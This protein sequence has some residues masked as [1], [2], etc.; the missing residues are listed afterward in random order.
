MTGPLSPRAEALARR[1]RESLVV[2]DGSTG[3]VLESLSGLHG[4]ALALLPLSR[5]E[6]VEALHGA[7]FAAGSDL[8]ETATFQANA[9]GLEGA[10]RRGVELDGAACHDAS[11]IAYRVNLEAARAAR[12]A[13]G[14]SPSRWVAG[15][16]GPGDRPPSLGASTWAGLKASYLPQAR[17][18]ADG[19]CDLALIETCQDPLQAKAAVA[20]LADPHGGRGLPFI[21]SATVDASGRLLAGTSI[22]AFVAIMAP[23]RPLAIGLNCSGGPAEL[24]P[25]LAE[26]A[27]LSPCPL[28]FMPNAG[29]PREEGGT[30]LWPLGPAEFAALVA[31]LA[32]RHGVSV[33]GGCCGTG[34][35]HLAR[36]SALL[37]DRPHPAPRP[38]PRPGLASLY[39][40]WPFFAPP[41]V[42]AG[43]AGSAR[44]FFRIGER[45]NSAGS[46]AFGSLIASGDFDG[47][48]AKAV[49]QEATGAQ[50]LDLHVSRPG[51]DEAIDLAGLAARLSG[52]ARA[53]ICLD[54]SEPAALEAALPAV[55]GRPL[56]NSAS[57]EDEA[58]ARRVFA[59]ARDFGAAVVCLAMDSHGPARTA[60][61]KARTCRALYDLAV[62]DFDLDPA[63]LLF[64][65]LTFTV[66]AGPPGSAAETLRAIP[67]IKAAC[68]GSLVVLGVGNISFGLPRAA[69]PSVTAVFL[70]LALEAGLDAAILDT[71]GVPEP[72]AVDPAI[73][74]AALALIHG[75]PEEGYDPLEV[76]GGAG[77]AS[78]QAADASAR[79]AAGAA[80]A[81][82]PEARLEAALLRGDRKVA[83]TEAKAILAAGGPTALAGAV[84]AAMAESGRLWLAG[85][86]P[87]PLV[88]RA[89]EAAK[90]VLALG[91]GMAGAPS[92]GC[93][94]L[95]TVKGDLHDIGKNIAGAI[96]AC[97]G[98]RVVDLGTDVDAPAIVAAAARESAFAVGLSGLLTRSLAE[99]RRTCEALERA[100]SPALVLAGGAAVDQGWAASSLE[101]CHPG[102]VV[103]CKD[104][105]DALGHL[106][107]REAVLAGR[108]GG[109][110]GG[111]PAGAAA[112]V[113][114]VQGAG[115]GE[116][117]PHRTGSPIVSPTGPSFHP[118]VLG[119]RLIAGLGLESL[120]EAVDRKTLFSARWG[121]GRGAGK[122]G[123]RAEAEREFDLLA[124]GLRSSGLVE[125]RAVA[126]FF[127]CRRRGET[128]LEVEDPRHAEPP[129]LLDFPREEAW[130]R[131][132]L[133]QYFSE[134]GDFLAAFA[135]TIGPKLGEEATRLRK[136]GSY[137]AYWR[138][139]GLG[140]ALAEAAAGLVHDR[141]GEEMVAAGAAG[142]G[143][144]YSFGFPACPGL[145]MQRPL[146]DLLGA[147]EAGIGLSEGFQLT[148]EHSITAF[149]VGR[150]DAVYFSA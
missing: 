124:T 126:G 27:D 16:M 39:E 35:E 4:E 62:G 134:G 110:D 135:V 116:G 37:K 139:H 33:V 67:L 138:L 64:D 93:I 48:A 21:V 145:E 121:Y 144:R 109:K 127:A 74:R 87:L 150:E 100:G 43:H 42:N 53:A 108:S 30:T 125:A 25:S 3:S 23:F 61:D 7:Y 52:L 106:E 142:M 92:R 91:A 133:A 78:G 128:G 119:P 123:S 15:S 96:L 65:P 130:P 40:A 9:Q 86:L 147:W 140:S 83:E 71:G 18:L 14:D 89:A 8:V 24:A 82:G 85:R 113:A 103:A 68:P 105:F 112:S 57:L 88:L 59:L 149:V 6:V 107:A 55:G 111:M 45:A 73:R 60:D 69:R 20:A 29:L 75:T 47:A 41:G 56:L 51:R 143:R 137:E 2:A 58:K 28:C 94:V 63:S 44:P 77:P 34:P 98:W 84:T 36:L 129:I 101:P 38:A 26:L 22:A 141:L 97:S 81:T 32:R 11:E 118:P 90:L 80:E 95:A 5:A 49:L 76:L 31:D 54:S 50:A 66:A 120:L 131:R 122:D 13:A 115:L 136:S 17:G 132:S 12:R 114:P 117:L 79:A 146:L 10:A 104:A 46:A 102:L 148:P 99:M 70:G 19:G 72:A 1:L